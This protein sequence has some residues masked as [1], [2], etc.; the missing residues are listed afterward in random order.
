MTILRTLAEGETAL[1]NQT[2]HSELAG[3]F[4][5]HWGNA[6][7]ATP[8]P[9]DSVARAAVY[10]DFGWLDYETRPLIDEASGQPYQFRQIPFRP[11]QLAAYDRWIDWLTSIDPYAGLLVSM[12]RTGLWQARYETMT[13]PTRG[14]DVS[15]LPPETQAFITKR[16]ASQAELRRQLDADSVQVNFHLL[17][18]WDLLSLYFCEGPRSEYLD[19]VPCAYDAPGNGHVRLELTPCGEREVALTPYPFDTRPLRMEIPY[20]VLPKTH[21]DDLADFRRA[22]FQAETRLLTYTAV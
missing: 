7:Y 11:E 17:Q 10:H 5:A 12:H 9:F 20:K 21:F 2:H 19:P 1:I 13:H 22:Y 16:E 3:H 6:D 18:V 8:R 4:A 14:Y 15:K